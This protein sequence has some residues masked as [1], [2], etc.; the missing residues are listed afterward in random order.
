MPSPRPV[1]LKAL[2]LISSLSLSGVALLTSADWLGGSKTRALFGLT[3]DALDG[4]TAES[5]PP[6]GLRADGGVVPLPDPAAAPAPAP[7]VP[8]EELRYLHGTKAFGGF[9][10]PQ[11]APHS[12]AGNAR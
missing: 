10:Y 12:D 4:R 5:S 2:V 9:G 6:R 1:W 8:S 11:V 7:K 3:P